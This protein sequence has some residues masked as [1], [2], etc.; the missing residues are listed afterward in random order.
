MHEVHLFMTSKIRIW[1]VQWQTSL[2]KFFDISMNLMIL[3]NIILWYYSSTCVLLENEIVFDDKQIFKYK[4]ILSGWLE[5]TGD[6][7]NKREKIANTFS[8]YF[9][10]GLSNT[11]KN[12]RTGFINIWELTNWM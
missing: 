5:K 11:E 6:P 1:R 3:Y 8:Y 4:I 10:Y 9:D 7:R 12:K 2:K